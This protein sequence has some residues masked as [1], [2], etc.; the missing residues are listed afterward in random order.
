MKIL[1]MVPRANDGGV[2]NY[3]NAL[4]GLFSLDVVYF[5]R[6]KANWPVS[7]GM[8]SETIRIIS[9]YYQFWRKL[10]QNN[11]SLIHVNTFMGSKSIKRDSVFILLSYLRKKKVILFF[12]G[13][14][15]RYAKKIEKRYLRFFTY[16]FFKCDSFITLSSHE[17]NKLVEL[18]YKKKIFIETTTVDAK[19]LNGVSEEGI[20]KKYHSGGIINLLFISRV[21]IEKGIY[22]VLDAF[23][24]LNGINKKLHLIIAGKGSELEDAK[25][26]AEKNCIDRVHFKGFVTGE[27]KKDVFT[28]S[29][30]L[31]FPTYFA[32]GMPNSVLEA[33]A[34]GLPVITTTA[35]GLKDIFT[36]GKNGFIVKPKDTDEIRQK[37][38]E[39]I[40]NP[41]LML[42]IG[43]TNYHYAKQCFVSTN[44]VKRLENIYREVAGNEIVRPHT[45]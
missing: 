38:D 28:R 45:R 6:G 23:R 12:R 22:E 1:V 32:E 13:W 37:I 42:S 41:D 31:V 4:N 8:I 15:E 25:Q 34:F 5:K 19:L 20:E 18:G 35:G 27:E 21:E 43:K 40:Q 17:K 39:L 9:D 16:I 3:F 14:D 29:H 33:F 7:S 2:A 10:G 44:V 36:D 26:F 24:Q 30:V 11:Y